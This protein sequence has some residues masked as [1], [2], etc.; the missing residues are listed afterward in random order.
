VG[1]DDRGLPQFIE[2]DKDLR[3]FKVQTGNPFKVN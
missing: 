1:A 3:A 2:F